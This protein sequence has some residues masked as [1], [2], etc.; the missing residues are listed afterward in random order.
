MMNHAVETKVGL[1][2][3]IAVIAMFSLYMWLNGSQFMQKG[4]IVEAEFDRIDDLRPGAPVK[5]IGVDIGRVSRVYFQDDKVIIEMRIQSNAQLPKRLKAMVTSAGVVGDKFVSIVPQGPN[6]NIILPNH[7]IPGQ[8]PVSME[9]LFT[10]TYQVITSVRD[11]ADSLKKFTNDPQISGSLKETLL[12]FNQ[13][14][15]DLEHMTSQLNDVNLVS[16]MRKVDNTMAVVERLATRNEPA[17]QELVANLTTASSQLSEASMTANRFLSDIS[18]DGATAASLKQTL[19]QIE[20]IS[21]DLEKFSAVLASKDKDVGLLINDAH[22]T[23]QSINEAAKTVDQAVQKLTS[24]SGGDPSQISTTIQGTVKAAAK[25][26]EYVNQ[27][28]KMSYQNSVAAGYGDE[29]GYQIDFYALSD[30]DRIPDSGYVTISTIT[31]FPLYKVI[32]VGITSIILGFLMILI[33]IRKKHTS[34][35]ETKG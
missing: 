29:S 11:I 21:A 12:R 8:S 26:S 13:I 7:R 19:T 33:K 4:Y 30:N 1:F 16:I 27:F 20:H 32:G 22:Q 25:V 17:I 6:E 34:N 31:T 28:E 9:Q 14:T 15:V 18:N 3:I 2:T 5:F 35:I 24:S 23:M 10:S